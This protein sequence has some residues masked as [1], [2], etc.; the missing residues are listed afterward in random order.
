MGKY[1][2]KRLGY[3]ILTLWIVITI[4]FALMHAIPGDPLAANARRLP[5]QIRANYYA[6]YGL[7]KPVTTQYVVYMKNLLKGDL[8]ESLAFAGRSV[9]TVIKDG[10][11]ASAR[12]GVQAVFI[13]FALGIALGIV[14]AFN[15]NK[16][17]DYIVMFI[18]LLGVSIPSFVFAALLQY[19]FTVKHMLLPTTGWGTFKH[20]ILPT[21]AL[22]LSPLAIYARYMRN[23]CLDVLGQDY[24]LTAKAKGVKIGRAHV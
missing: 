3:M 18:A 16:W 23:E 24:I 10:L 2:L 17:P 9:N 15:R 8:G 7:D 6:K 20:T 22:C 13:G 19:L 14:A 21:I 4:T 1:I 5:P 11:P 12:I